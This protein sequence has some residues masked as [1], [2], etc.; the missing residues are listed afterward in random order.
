[1]DGVFSMDGF[2]APLDEITALARKY[3]A[4]VHIDE[5]H[6]TGFLGASALYLR[7][8]AVISSSGAMKPSIEN[9]PS[10]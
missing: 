6:A 1:S 10:L 2:I 9:T 7:A 4:L 5:C 8:R 3:N